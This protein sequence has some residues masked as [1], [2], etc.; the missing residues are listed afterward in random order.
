[1]EISFENFKYGSFK[2]GKKAWV[3]INPSLNLD[4]NS[5]PVMRGYTISGRL[6]FYQNQFWIFRK[7]FYPC[8]F[9]KF[10]Q[11]SN[12]FSPTDDDLPF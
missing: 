5:I 10:F 1:M 3:S 6:Y 11:F 4:E 9:P 8:V 7:G 12:D 2:Q